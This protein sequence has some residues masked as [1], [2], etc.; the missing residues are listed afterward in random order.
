MRLFIASI[1]KAGECEREEGWKMEDGAR[2]GA[3]A[4]SASLRGCS[5]LSEH[6]R[7]P[8]KSKQEATQEG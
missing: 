5:L 6:N 2:D 7:A 4:G 1:T 8:H 3:A